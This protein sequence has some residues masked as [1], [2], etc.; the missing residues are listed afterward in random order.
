M[1]APAARIIAATVA[2]REITGP[3]LTPAHI[4][5]HLDDPAT[6]AAVAESPLASEHA[7]DAARRRLVEIGRR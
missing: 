6:L 5:A 7:K 2:A 1:T 4:I 3:L